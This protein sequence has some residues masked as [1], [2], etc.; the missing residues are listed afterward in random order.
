MTSHPDR[1]ADGRV[2][3]FGAFDAVQWTAEVAGYEG[4]ILDA[5][6]AGIPATPGPHK[7]G[8]DATAA[9]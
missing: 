1:F 6:P 4:A 5:M 9:V 3:V 7:P 8:G 2:A